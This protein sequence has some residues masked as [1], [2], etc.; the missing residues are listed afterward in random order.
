[1]FEIVKDGVTE[2]VLNDLTR[3]FVD[4][5]QDHY[6]N[7]VTPDGVL[8][9]HRCQIDPKSRTYA[10]MKNIVQRHF[11]GEFKFWTAYQKQTNP[12]RLHIDDYGK[13]RKNPTYTIVMPMFTDPRVKTYVFQDIFADNVAWQQHTATW[14]KM[15]RMKMKMNQP[16]S[17]ISETEDLEHTVDPNVNA[18]IADYLELDGIFHYERGSYVLFDSN[19]VHASSNWRKYPEYQS[20]EILQIHITDLSTTV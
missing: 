15:V 9:D 1:M 13:D 17:N 3:Y 11:K 5:T 12:H 7:W 6:V 20:K 8:I 4:H 10:N 18:Y 16:K 14:C 19:Q 2:E